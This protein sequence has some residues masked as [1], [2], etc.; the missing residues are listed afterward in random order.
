MKKILFIAV[1]IAACC[2][3]AASGISIYRNRKNI[4]EDSHAN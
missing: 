4:S 2:S 1:G 3:V